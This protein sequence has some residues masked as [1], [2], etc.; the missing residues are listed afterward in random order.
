MKSITCNGKALFAENKLSELYTYIMKI[1]GLSMDD[2]CGE[3]QHFQKLSCGNIF[4]AQSKKFVS[5]K[6]QLFPHF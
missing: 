1:K 5:V 6:L 3:I 2:L 4:L